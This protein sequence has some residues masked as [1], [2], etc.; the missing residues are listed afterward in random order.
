MKKAHI[1]SEI[2]MGNY[3]GGLIPLGSFGRLYRTCLRV[4][5]E[6]VINVQKTSLQRLTYSTFIT[7]V[8][9]VP[10]F[11]RD[12][13]AKRRCGEHEPRGEAD[14]LLQRTFQRSPQNCGFILASAFVTVNRKTLMYLSPK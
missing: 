13:T 9:S 4:V 2:T 7:R 8:L 12:P 11:F 14:Q 6:Q 3:C 10:I 5:T 1:G